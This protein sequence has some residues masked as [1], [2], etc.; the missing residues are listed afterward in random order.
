MWE[1]STF[2]AS[3]HARL[4]VAPQTVNPAMPTP[5]AVAKAVI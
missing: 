1:T 5:A 2:K 3:F 4:N